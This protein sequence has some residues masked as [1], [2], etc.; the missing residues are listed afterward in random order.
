MFLWNRLQS[1]LWINFSVDTPHKLIEINQKF[2]QML[3][4][5]ETN[6]NRDVFRDNDKVEYEVC[7]KIFKTEAEFTQ[8]KNEQWMLFKIIPLPFSIIISMSFLFIKVLLKVFF[9]Y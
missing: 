3:F 8:V 1:K 2:C 4:N 9:W 5:I 6:S 7:L